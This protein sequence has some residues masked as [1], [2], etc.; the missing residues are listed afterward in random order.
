MITRQHN[1]LNKKLTN[2]NSKSSGKHSLSP[3]L[4]AF[5][6]A[7]R[8]SVPLVS[9]VMDEDKEI[10]IVSV[11]WTTNHLVNSRNYIK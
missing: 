5:Y 11:A 1:G 6:E 8:T 10:I 3:T 4:I 9:I 2:L 7:N